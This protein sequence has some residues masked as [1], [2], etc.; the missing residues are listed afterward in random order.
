MG[1]IFD[2]PSVKELEQKLEK[3]DRHL[4]NLY[5]ELQEKEAEFTY[6]VSQP[7]MT[8][9]DERVRRISEEKKNLLE[10]IEHWEDKRR[11]LA[12]RIRRVKTVVRR[13]A[14]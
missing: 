5:R 4:Q 13:K 7:G 14:A 3:M 9:V 6:L 2:R 11:K 10:S 1:F 12:A 8:T